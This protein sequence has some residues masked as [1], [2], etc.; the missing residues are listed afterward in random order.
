VCFEKRMLREIF[1]CKRE[2]VVEGWRR[3]NNKKLHSLYASPSIIRVMKSKQ[4]I[5]NFVSKQYS[6]SL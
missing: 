3:L 4:M 6:A 1:R 5:T 2:E